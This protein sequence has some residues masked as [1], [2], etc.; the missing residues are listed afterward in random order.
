MMYLTYSPISLSLEYSTFYFIS[1][2]YFIHCLSL[3]HVLF[4]L[5]FIFVIIHLKIFSTPLTLLLPLDLT[6]SPSLYG[7]E[8]SLSILLNPL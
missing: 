3:V 7:A 4:F 8:L 6:G 1:L 2:R 5:R